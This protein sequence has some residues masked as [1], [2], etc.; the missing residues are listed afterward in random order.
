MNDIQ[1]IICGLVS[2]HCRNT[3]EWSVQDNSPDGV[4]RLACSEHV[5]W[6]LNWDGVSNT[7]FAVE[8]DGQR[9]VFPG[10]RA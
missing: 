6:M 3:A 4:E 7:V 10:G 5:S 8:E 2:E 1:I 9:I